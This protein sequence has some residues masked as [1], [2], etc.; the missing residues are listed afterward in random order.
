[1]DVIPSTG[2][3]VGCGGTGSVVGEGDGVGTADSVDVANDGVAVVTLPSP[4]GVVQLLMNSSRTT[5]ITTLRITGEIL[6]GWHGENI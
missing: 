3:T 5:K 2:V 1:V 4:D 6:P